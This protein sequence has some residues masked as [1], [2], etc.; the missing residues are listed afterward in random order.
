MRTKQRDALRAHL[1]ERGVSTA[2]H[3]PF[4]IHRTE[5]YADLGLGEGSLPVAERLAEE[6]CTLPLFPTM[7]DDEVAHVVDAVRDFDREESDMAKDRRV[8]GSTSADAITQPLRVAVVGYGYWGPNLVRNVIERPEL[9]LA[10]PV[11]AR[12]RSARRRSRRR[13]PG[14]PVFADL[15]DVLAD[16]T[17]D[18][19]VVA[20]P[21]RTHHAIVARRAAR[22]ASTCSSRSRWPRRPPRRAT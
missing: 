15:D 9:E 5:A 16:P 4:P 14:V 13:C 3:Y 19:V 12:R 1:D 21:P 20:T 6:I 18:A 2:V 17:I 10:G 7:S 22:P 11:R 8:S